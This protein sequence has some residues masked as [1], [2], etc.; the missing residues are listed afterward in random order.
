MTDLSCLAV[1]LA[2]GEG[3]R[4]KSDLPKVL[5]AVGG[6]PLIDAVIESARAGGAHRLAIVIGAG[7]DKVRAH[8]G[9]AAPDAQVFEQRERLGTAHAA[10]AAREALVH[11]QGPVLVLFGDTPLVRPETIAALIGR[12]SAGADIALLGFTTDA[13]T[14]YGRLIIK[15][16]RL[17]AIIEER[18]ADAAT[19]AI[20]LCNSGIM[21]FRAGLLPELLE[22]IGNAN[23]KG[24]YYLTDAIALGTARGLRAE[25]VIGDD[26]SEFVGINDRVQLAAAEAIFQQRARAEAMAAGV[27]LVAPDTVFF[28]FDTKLDRDVVVDPNVVFAPGVQVASGTVIRAFSHLEGARVASGAVIG[29]YARLRPGADLAENVHVGNFVEIKNARVDQGAKVNHLTYIGDA[30]IGA[31][32]NVGAGTITCNYD[33][34]FKHKTIIGADVFVGSNTVMVAPVTVGNNALTA[35]GSVITADVPDGAMAFG[36]ARQEVKEGMGAAKKAALAAK[37]AAAKSSG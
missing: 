27:T 24:E 20:R 16:E 10:L 18:E 19:K 28:S 26:E 25:A 36:R 22:A 29:P 23:A 1:V 9:K 8:L 13:P 3:T 11:H 37:K 17:V 6:R 7:A 35:A 33:G 30:A 34:V 32:T 5:H 2:A 14:G 21:A 12:L 4:M 15:D 31:R